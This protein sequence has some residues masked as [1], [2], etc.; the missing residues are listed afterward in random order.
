M[1]QYENSGCHAKDI[2]ALDFHA[3][4]A[5]DE[6]MDTRPS[7]NVSEGDGK[8][9]TSAALASTSAFNWLTERVIQYRHT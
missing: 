1:T 6:T 2:K 7:F 3:V 5:P 9:K 8:D 4:V